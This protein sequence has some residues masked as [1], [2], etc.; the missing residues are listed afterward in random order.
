MIY[1]V[2][3]VILPRVFEQILWALVVLSWMRLAYYNIIALMYQL[4]RLK[5]KNMETKRIDDCKLFI[6][7]F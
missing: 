3:I 1:M 4:R 5:G 2:L 7:F 6:Y